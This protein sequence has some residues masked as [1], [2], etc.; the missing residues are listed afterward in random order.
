MVQ[1]VVV[2]LCVPLSVGAQ[3]LTYNSSWGFRTESERSSELS[4]LDLELRKQGGFYDSFETNILYDGNTFV[5][6]DCTG[7]N[8]NSK[9]NDSVNSQDAKTSSPNTGSELEL[10]TSALGNA[11]DNLATDYGVN[12][13][14]QDASGNISSDMA[15]SLQNDTGVL[16]AS[17]GSSEQKS[18]LAQTND[19]AVTSSA[20]SGTGCNFYT[21][22][23]DQRKAGLKE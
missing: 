9:A 17:G 14:S 22:R 13:A 16:N 15:L 2:L 1:P 5:T 10:E 8:A 18:N 3:S 12:T 6:Y 21:P 20:E 11:S 23:P 19:G 4:R 7:S